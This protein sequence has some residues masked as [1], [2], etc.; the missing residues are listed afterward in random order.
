MES[1]AAFD[2]FAD[3][4]PYLDADD[5]SCAA[6]AVFGFK[7]KK[8]DLRNLLEEY[9]APNAPGVSRA[10]FEKLVA[11]RRKLLG[12]R[13][14]AYRMFA[15]LDKENRGCLEM[16]TFQQTFAAVCRPAATRA[17][18]I[19]VAMDRSKSGAVTFADFEAYL[20]GL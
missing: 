11:D 1:A 13:D 16:E 5:L 2:A 10:G 12:E 19:F 3:G 15:A 9:A 4:K 6:I 18:E 7:F 14:R 20:A 8:D 17:D